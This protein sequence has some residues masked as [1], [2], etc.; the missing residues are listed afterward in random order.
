VF[1][2]LLSR[3]F[4]CDKA[5]SGATDIYWDFFSLDAASIFEC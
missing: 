3:A 4:G 2:G 1:S 5:K